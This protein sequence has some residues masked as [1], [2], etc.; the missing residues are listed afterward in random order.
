MAVRSN[1]RR[2]DLLDK[3]IL[4][5]LS[6]TTSDVTLTQLRVLLAI[7][8]SG[9][10]TM[11]A[12]QLGI[13]QSG[14]SQAVAGLESALQSAVLVRDR[15][16]ITP[17]AL[18]EKVLSHARI[19]LAHVEC[20]QQEAAAAVG[21]ATGRLRLGSVPSA[22]TRLLPPLLHSFRRRHP[23]TELVLLE[24]TDQEVREWVLSACG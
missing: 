6:M 7:I 11:A 10:F 20:I 5:I 15:H 18:G 8:D 9:S 16:G 12:E 4:V 23:S 17:T 14:V 22:A 13:T 2:K 19:A 3:L 24:G 21:L 1:I